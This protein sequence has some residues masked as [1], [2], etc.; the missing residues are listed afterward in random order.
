[1]KH[2]RGGFPYMDVRVN[3]KTGLQ[4]ADGQGGSFRKRVLISER[5]ISGKIF[6]EDVAGLKRFCTFA[7]E[8]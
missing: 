3:G 7:I 8:K 6:Q 2:T 1:M 4:W 5:W